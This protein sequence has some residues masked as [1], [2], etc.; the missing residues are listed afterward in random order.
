MRAS[1][2]AA[3]GWTFARFPSSTQAE[4][5]Q[6]GEHDHDEADQINDV[7]HEKPPG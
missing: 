2:V 7:V 4:E 3:C 5:G 1:S 6:D